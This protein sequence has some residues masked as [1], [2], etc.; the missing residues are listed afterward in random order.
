[1]KKVLQLFIIVFASFGSG[2]STVNGSAC[3]IQ[4]LKR[5]IKRTRTFYGAEEIYFASGAFSRSAAA[6]MSPSAEEIRLA[7][8]NAY[9]NAKKNCKQRRFSVCGANL[10]ESPHDY[11]EFDHPMHSDCDL[12][13]RK[14]GTHGD[15]WNPN[16]TLSVAAQ[17]NI[18]GIKYKWMSRKKL[19]EKC[20]KI[21]H[22]LDDHGSRSAK[23]QKLQEMYTKYNCVESS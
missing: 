21:E 12:L 8:F 15:F 5:E 11:I 10:P 22:C 19:R 13:V 2:L 16:I 6:R 17:C 4:E 1:M 9:F 23:G 3:N 14:R 20:E 18:H 7:R